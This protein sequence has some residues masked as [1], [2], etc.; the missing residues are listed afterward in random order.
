V[1]ALCAAV[2]QWARSR[3]SS[4]FASDADLANLA[5]HRMR[6][7]LGFAE[8]ERVVYFHKFLRP[9]SAP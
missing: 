5:S 9:G 2:E 4:E 7:A 3:G 8:T 6:A 1:G